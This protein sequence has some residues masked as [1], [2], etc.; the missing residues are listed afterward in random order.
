M[1]DTVQLTVFGVLTAL[2]VNR[3]VFGQREELALA[4]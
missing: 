3:L 4:R 1:I 2:I